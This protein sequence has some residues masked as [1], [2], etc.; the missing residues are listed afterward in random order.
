MVI[1]KD[2]VMVNSVGPYKFDMSCIVSS[3]YLVYDYRGKQYFTDDEITA[4]LAFSAT[5]VPH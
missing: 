2:M 3:V 4:A 1:L 5:N